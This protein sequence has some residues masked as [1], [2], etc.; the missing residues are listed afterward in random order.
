MNSALVLIGLIVLAILAVATSFLILVRGRFYH[1]LKPER[2]PR[3]WVLFSML[4]LFGVFLIWFALWVCMP[5]SAT[6]WAATLAFGFTFFA[7][8][9]TIKW[10][11]PLVDRL[12]K[13]RGWPL[14]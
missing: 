14:R 12:I 3:R 1:W 2:R 4:V 9:I 5:H 8:G 10:F 13:R 7:V 11:T 6:T